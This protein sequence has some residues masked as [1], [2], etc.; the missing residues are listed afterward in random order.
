MSMYNYQ[1]I[2][3]YLLR[4]QGSETRL[5]TELASGTDGVEHGSDAGST[6]SDDENSGEYEFGDDILTLKNF[7]FISAMFSDTSF[8]VH[9]LVQTAARV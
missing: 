2:P 3:E 4:A 6:A 8:K 7:H 9:R 1:G 5:S